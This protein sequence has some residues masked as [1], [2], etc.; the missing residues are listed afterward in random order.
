MAWLTY[1]IRYNRQM[2]RNVLIIELFY[3]EKK[4]YNDGQVSFEKFCTDLTYT[5][6]EAEQKLLRLLIRT[7]QLSVYLRVFRSG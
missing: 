7:Y 2:K 5:C 3:T 6:T 4:T 1:C